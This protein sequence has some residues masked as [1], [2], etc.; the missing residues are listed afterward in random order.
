MERQSKGSRGLEAYCKGGQGAPRAVAP[1]KKKC[2]LRRKLRRD[3][4]LPRFVPEK[5]LIASFSKGTD[6]FGLITLF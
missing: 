4:F 6:V 1:P 2:H 5:D 3:F